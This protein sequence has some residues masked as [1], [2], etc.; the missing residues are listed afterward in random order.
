VA[1]APK[2]CFAGKVPL[3]SSLIFRAPQAS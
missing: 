2:H 3:Q 1:D